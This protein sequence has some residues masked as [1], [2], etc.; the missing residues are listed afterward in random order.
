MSSPTIEQNNAIN[1]E[2]N[3]AI[4]S[5]GAG[6][7]K[8]F[9]LKNRVQRL[10]KDKKIPVD[11]LV[12]L[13]FTNN[14]A[15][16]MK[17]RIRKVVK[18]TKEI[19]NQLDSVDSAYITT[20]DSFAQSIVKKYNYLLDIDKHFTIIDENIVNIELR[21]ILN[22]IFNSYYEHPTKEFDN[23]ISDFCYK[24]DT[25]LI[26]TI[27]SMYRT[28]TNMKDKD[29][30]LN[31]YVDNYL[32]NTNKLN[33]FIKEYK[34]L[35]LDKSYDLIPLYE[36]YIEHTIDDNAKAK[37]EERIDSISSIKD[38]NELV[39][40][41]NKRKPQNTNGHPVYDDEDFKDIK[42]ATRDLEY[43]IK[44]LASLSN[45]ELINQFLYTKD[46]VLFLINILKELDK[47]ILVFK[48][49]RNAYEFQDIALLALKLVNMPEIASILKDSIDEIMIDEYQDTSD[50]QDEFISHISNNN[51][52][53]VGDIKQSIY[54]F[55][56]ANP[57][58]FKDK[59]DNYDSNITKKDV[60]GYRIDMTKNFRSRSEVI[61]NINYIFS[62]IMTDS[63]GG[64]SY[65]KDHQMES[66]KEEYNK[67]KKEGFNYNM[68]IYNYNPEGYEEYGKDVIEAFIIAKD[69]KEKYESK[70]LIMD[71]EKDGVFNPI[72]YKDFCILVDKSKNFELLK[73]VLEFFG[74]PSTIYKDTS[75]K[76][77]DEVFILKNL[78][79]LL[80][81][82]KNN[83]LNE[84]FNHSYMSIARSYI[85]HLSDQEIYDIFTNNTF[86]D[87]PLYNKLLNIT[88]DID[89][90]SNKDILIK[91]IDEFDIFNKLI[92][93]GDVSIRSS[94][95]EYFIN[96]ADSLNKFGLD[97]YSLEQYF[98]NILNS[99]DDFKMT[100]KNA[101]ANA[102]KIMTIHGS[103][104][105]EFPI[106]Y[107][108]YLGSA[109]K[110]NKE[111]RYPLSDKYGFMIDYKKDNILDK[112]FVK[113]IYDYN[114]LKENVSEKIRLLY[115]A[116][117]RAREKFIL[118]NTWNDK[119]QAKDVINPLDIL[120]CKN[121]R[122]ILS[123]MKNNLSSYIKDINLKDLKLTDKYNQYQDTNYDSLIKNIKDKIETK[124]LNLTYNLVDNK[125]FSKPMSKL[126][127]KNLRNTLDMG[128]YMHYVFEV[129][130]FNPLNVDSLDVSDE[131]KDKVKKFFNHDISKNIKDAKVYKEHEIR[132]MKDGSIYHG[133]I[134]LLVEYPDHFDIIDYKLS[135][136]DSEEY[137]IQ[138]NG[139]KNYIEEKYHKPTN[140][141]LYSINRDEFKS[142]N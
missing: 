87:T 120:H 76:E 132:F 63:V 60:S 67:Y 30:F 81:H 22:N 23:F 5:A 116:I 99:D 29:T 142:L 16:E 58:I 88:K 41:L 27:I 109:F 17:D 33:E 130:K 44:T 65:Q 126:I 123:I 19:S 77:D 115:V 6:S 134:D 136:L 11:R 53:M 122:D 43:D 139:Y 21:N 98:D 73:K 94:K 82:I 78:I 131:V 118:I 140:I 114:E 97:I 106:V 45:E 138:L 20:F 61:N 102:V 8:T 104:G 48:K 90:L 32:N 9:V 56:H 68:E 49:K 37:L 50:I 4:V 59:Y 103:K 135:N 125:H 113:T 31:N 35:I 127:D 93:V 74:I 85:Y 79:T 95:L 1:V 80:T 7:G 51:V 129:T 70:M 62:L 89:G 86:K 47:Q 117:T 15:A 14:A 40:I 71:K 137:V 111:T 141:Y 75:I 124:E 108:P 66:G 42:T 105:L 54:R 96:N 55:R 36:I 28:L 110:S 57:Y 92:E 133:F 83:E 72:D 12:I 52:Y 39:D 84:D 128:T 119:V 18:E 26:E 121:Y 69:I 46:N 101:D 107:L 34:Q 112:T 25:D 10:V 2:G 64:A 38:V 91:L 3:N 100:G 24:D 13:T